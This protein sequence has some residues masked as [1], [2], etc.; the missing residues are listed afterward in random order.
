MA[1]YFQSAPAGGL[2]GGVE[3]VRDGIDGEELPAEAA[4]HVN[5]QCRHRLFFPHDLG[6]AGFQPQR[7]RGFDVHQIHGVLGADDA[8]ILADGFGVGGRGLDAIH[9]FGDADKH[10]GIEVRWDGAE[11]RERG[12]I[13]GEGLRAIAQEVFKRGPLLGAGADFAD[14]AQSPIEGLRARRDVGEVGGRSAER[15]GVA[16]LPTRKA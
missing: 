1:L 10:A 16:G 7:E 5:L 13:R 9:D 15:W 14:L 6:L 2:R 11:R 3:V 12:R 4:A 8:Q